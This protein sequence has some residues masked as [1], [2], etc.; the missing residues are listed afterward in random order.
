MTDAYWDNARIFD[1][2]NATA[3]RVEVEHIDLYPVKIYIESSFIYDEFGKVD[4]L[5]ENTEG[6]LAEFEDLAVKINQDAHDSDIEDVPDSAYAIFKELNQVQLSPRCSIPAYSV[7]RGMVIGD[8]LDAVDA[9]IFKYT[10]C[11]NPVKF[12]IRKL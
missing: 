1:Y 5:T 7:F 8:H 12:Y 11:A 10:H 6:A 3:P 2:Y 9:L 4:D